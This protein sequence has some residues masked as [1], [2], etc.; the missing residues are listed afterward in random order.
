MNETR[1]KPT[2]GTQCPTLS[3]KWQGIFYMPSRT[4]TTDIPRPLIPHWGERQRAPAQG[5]LEPR[6][7]GPQ[8]NTPT[9]RPLW[10]PQV[11]GSSTPWVLNGGGGLLPN[12]GRLRNIPATCRPSPGDRVG[13][14]TRLFSHANTTWTVCR[15][16][17]TTMGL[18]VTL[19]CVDLMHFTMEDHPENRD[20]TSYS[21]ERL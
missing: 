13:Q 20:L 11:G 21:V 9:T 14:T 1:R 16:Y 2:T 17:I 18:R 15:T 19:P 12:G 5:R 4:D 7:V 3:D 8:S 6:P 10:P